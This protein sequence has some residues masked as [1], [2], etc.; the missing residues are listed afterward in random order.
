MFQQYAMYV[1]KQREVGRE[2]GEG[3]EVDRKRYKQTDTDRQTETRTGIE[4]D[5]LRDTETHKQRQRG[6]MGDIK[7]LLTLILTP[8]DSSSRYNR[9]K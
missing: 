9:Q 3:G 7:P 1:T 5:R 4:T 8:P 6:E 2:R